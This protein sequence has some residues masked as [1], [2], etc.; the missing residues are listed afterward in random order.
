MLTAGR[1]FILTA[2]SSHQR[3]CSKSHIPDTRERQL[4][5]ADI[6]IF[7]WKDSGHICLTFQ[8]CE[9]VVSGAA[10]G[11]AV[12]SVPGWWAMGIAVED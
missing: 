8:V 1:S 2:G 3:A 12:V 10:E 6:Q 11:I 7:P 4:R 5:E 9:G